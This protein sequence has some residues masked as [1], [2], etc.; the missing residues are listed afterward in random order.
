MHLAF[1]L[2]LL[3]IHVLITPPLSLAAPTTAS[4]QSKAI[5]YL[6]N[7]FL[8]TNADT[9]HAEIDYYSSAPKSFPASK[10]KL[11]SV[12][13]PT[14]SIDYEDGRVATLPGS[15]F[16]LTVTIGEDTYTAKQE[17]WLKSSM[18]LG[19]RSAMRIMP[20]LDEARAMI[21][22][23]GFAYGFKGD[24]PATVSTQLSFIEPDPTSHTPFS[25]ASVHSLFINMKSFICIGLAATLAALATAESTS[26][27]SIQQS[28]LKRAYYTC[29]ETYG[30]GSISCGPVDNHYC[31]NPTLGETCCLLDDG[32]CGAGDFCAPVAGFCCHNTETPGVCAARLSFSLPSS[33]VAT[34][35]PAKGTSTSSAPELPTSTIQVVLAPSS[36]IAGMGD[37]VSATMVA[38][39]TAP[40]NPYNGTTTVAATASAKGEATASPTYLQASDAVAS[41]KMCFGAVTAVVGFVALVL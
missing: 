38:E 10:P 34:S 1:T 2:R 39:M 13:N 18:N 19:I 16:N 5:F 26:H 33:S 12:L 6:T 17:M 25:S 3:P 7:C 24:G 9:Q 23:V 32:Y 29:Q 35:T 22:D 14:E 27:R 37:L 40:V 11:I 21:Q 15:P 28:K 8:S 41:A 31:Y 30:A 36:V 4:A 20:V